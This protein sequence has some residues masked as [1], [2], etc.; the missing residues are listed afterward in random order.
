MAGQLRDL[1]KSL[2]DN[3]NYSIKIQ[4]VNPADI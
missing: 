1:L 3:T 2:P 4:I